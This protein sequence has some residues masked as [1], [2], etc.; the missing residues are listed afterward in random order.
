[1]SNT[2]TANH[3]AD[4]PGKPTFNRA[5]A[6]LHAN[7]SV[8]QGDPANPSMQTFFLSHNPTQNVLGSNVAVILNRRIAASDKNISG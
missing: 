1:M 8:R 4:L 5:G 7:A 3:T 2:P 6:A